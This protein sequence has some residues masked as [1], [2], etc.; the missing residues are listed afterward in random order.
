V[1]VSI[2]STAPVGRARRRGAPH[3]PR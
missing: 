2:V 3:P 1:S